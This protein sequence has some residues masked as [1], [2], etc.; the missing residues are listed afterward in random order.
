MTFSDSLSIK[1]PRVKQR[2]WWSLP[3]TGRYILLYQ[4][5]PPWRRQRNWVQ[6]DLEHTEVLFINQEGGARDGEGSVQQDWQQPTVAKCFWAFIH[7]LLHLTDIYRVSP[8]CPAGAG[9]RD[10]NSFF[11]HGLYPPGYIFRKKQ[12]PILKASSPVTWLH[13]LHST[14]PERSPIQWWTVSGIF[15]ATHQME[16]F[17][18]KIHQLS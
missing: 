16:N 18:T 2:S 17:L 12:V 14:W 5:C 15:K 8:A 6:C 4:V 3:A 13:F 1:Q 11:S 10:R 9:N 7:L